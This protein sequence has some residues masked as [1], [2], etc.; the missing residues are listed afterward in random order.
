MRG[1]LMNNKQQLQKRIQQTELQIKKLGLNSGSSD[2][3][4]DLYNSLILQKAILK[5]QLQDAN[6]N[7]VIEGIKKFIP[8]REK[9]ICDYFKG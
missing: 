5:K 4:E 3:C 1:L 7:P 2:V 6:K 9:L 8:H